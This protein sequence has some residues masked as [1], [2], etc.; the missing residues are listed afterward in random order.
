MFSNKNGI[1]YTCSAI[2]DAQYK[3]TENTICGGAV[4][5]S[6]A[7]R[8]IQETTAVAHLLALCLFKLLRDVG[9]RLSGIRERASVRM[10]YSQCETKYS[11]GEVQIL[12]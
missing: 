1:G 9:D 7:K 2:F 6:A 8:N 11:Y 10:G 3:D 5:S 12:P 4:T